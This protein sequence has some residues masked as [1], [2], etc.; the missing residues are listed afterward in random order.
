MGACEFVFNWVCSFYVL[1][2]DNGQILHLVT[3][4]QAWTPETGW[5]SL[6]PTGHPPSTSDPQ[7]ARTP[8]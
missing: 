4:R 6:L 2:D 3:S 1:Y 5:V 7:L 8:N